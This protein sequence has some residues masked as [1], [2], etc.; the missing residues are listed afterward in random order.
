MHGMGELAGNGEASISLPLARSSGW[1][2]RSRLSAAIPM[3]VSLMAISISFPALRALTQTVPLPV[4][5][6]A[7]PTRL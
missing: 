5:L 6:M 4:Y 3:P 1:K 7:L 2:T